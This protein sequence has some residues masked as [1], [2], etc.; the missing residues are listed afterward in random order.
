VPSPTPPPP[1]TELTAKIRSLSDPLALL[2]GLFALSPLA[3]QVFGADGQSLLVNDAFRRILGSEPPPEYN[4]FEDEILEK[5]G[6]LY[7]IRR[8]FA[9]ETLQLPPIWYDPRELRRFDV[10]GRRVGVEVTMFPLRDASGAVAHVALCS[11][12]VTAELELKEA[13]EALR[14]SEEQLRQSQ[15]ME[16]VGRLAGGVAHDFNN[17]L[18]VIQAY[19]EVLLRKAPSQR[20][21]EKIQEACARAAGL[22]RQLLAFSRQQVLAP[23]VLELNG[24]VESIGAMMQRV[25]GEDVEVETRLAPDL[26]NVKADP[27]QMEQ[28]L[29]NLLVNARDAMPGGGM[30]T[31]ATANVAIDE[32]YAR[33]HPD[34]TAGPHVMVSVSD[35]GAGMDHATLSRIFEPFFTTKDKSKGTGLGLATVL[36][37]VQQSGGHI[38]VSSRQG[39]GS[40][41]EIYL[42]RSEGVADW[43]PP[44][45]TPP[46][47]ETGDETV[48]LV[49]DDDRVRTVVAELLESAGYEV[50]QA[51]N[52]EEAIAIAE[53]NERLQLLLTDIVMPRMNGRQ[54]AEKVRAVRPGLR[55]VFMSGYTDHVMMDHGILGSEAFFLQKPFTSTSLLLKVREALA[56]GPRPP[57]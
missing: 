4:V 57:R 15:K 39:A 3:F 1:M 25:L 40:T 53:Q 22:T 41:F 45:S 43:T 10:E 49:E 31:I 37:I 34:V 44:R 5:Q 20:E 42:P 54:L 12:D 17:L 50:L 46:V 52:P 6:F 29:L 30:V 7:L 21:I 55:D 2:E 19:C 28:V 47:V 16:A 38:A 8:A 13:L 56:S 26:G 51:R 35:T 9:G 11:K 48:L 32:A 27:G 18:S 24:I 14:R 23:R 33:E 36:G